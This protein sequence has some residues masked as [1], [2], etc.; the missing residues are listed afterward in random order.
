MLLP[1]LEKFEFP[2]VC[3]N[4]AKAFEPPAPPEKGLAWVCGVD[5]ACGAA[6][7]GDALLPMPPTAPKPEPEVLGAPIVDGE[8]KAGAAGLAAVAGVVEPKG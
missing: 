6:A 8:P 5:V 1:K 3:P 2:P 7:Q 4:L